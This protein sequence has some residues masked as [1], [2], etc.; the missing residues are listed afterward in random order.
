M[1][2]RTYYIRKYSYL[3]PVYIRLFY[4]IGFDYNNWDPYIILLNRFRDTKASPSRSGNPSWRR[5]LHLLVRGIKTYY[6]SK[7]SFFYSL[8]STTFVE[9]P[10]FVF[11]VK[12]AS[13]SRSGNPSS[14]RRQRLLVHGIDSSNLS[15][16]FSII[17]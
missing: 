8:L 9:F 6:I 14:T 13:P 11:R 7:C 10:F 15:S 2:H 4:F 3:Y 17:F 16:V 12:K 5:R 1:E